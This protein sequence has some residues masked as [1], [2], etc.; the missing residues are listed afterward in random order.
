MYQL[1]KRS[2]NIGK[3]KRNSH[4]LL[5]RKYQRTE[6]KVNK[7][8]YWAHFWMHIVHMAK[9]SIE[10]GSTLEACSKTNNNNH[11]PFLFSLSLFFPFHIDAFLRFS[12]LNMK[13][14]VRLSL[15][16]FFS[17]KY[18][19][20]VA[21]TLVVVAVHS[22][23]VSFLKVVFISTALAPIDTRYYNCTLFVWNAVYVIYWW[24]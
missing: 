20:V 8:I 9:H 6:R 22:D 5:S 16:F 11:F 24:R 15:Y 13:Y 18:S 14:L 10:I 17:K 3:K 12:Y 4:L 23:A 19:I 7:E 21:F 1:H 2:Y